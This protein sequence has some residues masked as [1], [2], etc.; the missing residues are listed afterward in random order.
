MTLTTTV[1]LLA[2]ASIAGN[3]DCEPN[4][5]T[6]VGGLFTS[7]DVAKFT[8]FDTGAG[9]ELYATGSFASG[10]VNRIA[11]W[12]GSQWQPLGSGLSNQYGNDLVEYQGD[13]YVG[14]YFDS[15]GGAADSAKIARWDPDTQTWFGLG[16]QQSLFLNSVWSLK[17]WDDG[18]GEA[19]YIGGNYVD[20]GGA[21]G[22]DFITRWDGTSFSE[23]GGTIGGI[24]VA[25]IVL[26]IEVFQGDLY[27]GGRFTE[28]GGVAASHIAR[29]DGTQ[30]HDVGGGIT[31]T[32]VIDM[33]VADDG[34]GPALFVGGS[35]TAAGGV[36]ATR[37]AK[38]DGATWSALPGGAD[39]TVQGIAGF[40]DGSGEK[41]FI[42][43]NFNNVDGQPAPRIARWDGFSLEPVGAGADANCF[44]VFPFNGRLNIGGSFTM[45]DNLPSGRAIQLLDCGASNPADLNGDGV[46]NSADLGD[47]LGQWGQPGSADFDNDGT[48]GPAD[49]ATLL[50][51]W[52]TN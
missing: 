11:R 4:W 30:W 15:A 12:D 1:A 28:V 48:V 7:G 44:A 35:F 17:T 46:V 31:G 13:L 20:M 42:V 39:S 52:T 16:A 29:W 33:A 26:D 14:G 23:V 47:L 43:G 27:I 18:N 50:G 22:P 2:S 25:L 19:L 36:P 6:A 5:D 9:P 38:W 49:L 41:V 51:S 24:G 21:G 8:S 10:G 40:D 34:S 32:Q 45:M 3:P 37:L